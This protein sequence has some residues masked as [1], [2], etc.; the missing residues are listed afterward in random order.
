MSSV[1]AA[2]KRGVVVNVNFI[3]GLPGETW[4]EAWKTY[5]LICRLAAAGAH[6]TA[7]MVFNP[8]P[9]SALFDQIHAAGRIELDDDF[10]FSSLLR[11]ARTSVSYNEPMSP[12]ALVLVQLGMLSSFFGI[13]YLLRP[14]RLLK[15]LWNVAAREQQETNLEQFL[16]T[17]WLYWKKRRETQRRQRLASGTASAPE[18]D[19]A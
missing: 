4:R 1:R 9:G 2:V 8:Y 7:V 12:M 10:Y 5:K 16:G 13:Q 14:Q 15:I 3:L 11:S 19:A 6:S 17:K 18:R